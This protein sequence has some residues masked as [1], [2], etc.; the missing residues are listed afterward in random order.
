[1]INLLKNLN[2][3]SWFMLILSAR[4][5]GENENERMEH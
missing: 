5:R 2:I 3:K 1:M 4:G